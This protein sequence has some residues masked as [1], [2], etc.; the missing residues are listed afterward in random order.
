MYNLAGEIQSSVGRFFQSSGVLSE[1]SVSYPRPNLSILV[2]T[3]SDG[4]KP[5]LRPEVIE[6]VNK[7]ID[8]Y[9]ALRLHA[10]AKEIH[11]IGSLCTNQ[12]EDDSDLDVHVIPYIEKLPK[13]KS[14]EEWQKDVK[15]FNRHS[16]P[17]KIGAHPIELFLQLDTNQDFLADS[18]YD[19]MKKTWVKPPYFVPLDFNP[20]EAYEE[21]F[22]ELTD[23]AAETDVKLGEL[24]RDVI[25]YFAI[26]DAIQGLPYELKGELKL[27][28]EGKVK[29]CER[30]VDELLKDKKAW[31]DMR[32]A[33]SAP[34][35]QK[36]ALS[37][38]NLVKNWKN[39][40][41]LFKL[42]SRY[43]YMKIISALEGLAE[44]GLDG[45]EMDALKVILRA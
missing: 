17:I 15:H 28:L 12:Y 43:H 44:D 45:D 11:I 10:I 35:S 22:D 33:A 14:A 29:E 38:V 36:S 26:K 2:W 18:L 9:T 6:L 41:A 42:L 20:N 24:K 3:G 25:D 34:I 13:S 27:K 1:S 32:K 30:V 37:D 40:N 8:R 16:E 5:V 23:I 21:A 31:V 7:A 39:K 19:F 4:G